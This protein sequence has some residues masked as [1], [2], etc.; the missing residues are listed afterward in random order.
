MATCAEILNIKLDQNEG[1]D[2]FSIV[3]LFQKKPIITLKGLIQSTTLLMVALQ[4]ERGIISSFFVQVLVGG[5]HLNHLIMKLRI[6]LNSSFT[7]WIMTLQNQT[8]FTVNY[9]N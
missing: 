2:S 9:Q 3:P 1:V 4:L 8:T 5:A 6:F 7:I